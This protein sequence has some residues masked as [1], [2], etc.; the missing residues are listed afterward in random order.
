MRDRRS[1]RRPSRT[2]VQPSPVSS[3]RAPAGP[4]P[5]AILLN[6]RYGA[7]SARSR[8]RQARDPQSGGPERSAPLLPLTLPAMLQTDRHRAR[9]S[10]LSV[11][12]LLSVLALLALACFPVLAQA[13]S[14]AGVQY[15]DAPPTIKVPGHKTKAHH[16][17]PGA[18]TS[19][20]QNGVGGPG[21]G[22]GNSGGGKSGGSS[23]GPSGKSSNPS[24]G[25]DA[26]T[27]Q[28]NPGNGSSS[29][30]KGDTQGVGSATGT[31]AS[32]KSSGGSSPLVPI[33]IAIAL[34][35]AI[36]IGVVVMRQRRQQR[37]ADS[38]VSPK[39]S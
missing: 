38:A 10:A 27:G 39:A 14:A 26:G 9:S 32:S 22:S 37:D 31:P 7:C 17:E 28:S 33:L 5:A 12:S 35:A 11:F 21:A 3:R 1:A 29:A 15:E 18:N 8:R 13:E 20:S 25:K 23:G 6:Q 34:L 16:E 4:R 36:S 2:V 30:Q 24:T 19:N